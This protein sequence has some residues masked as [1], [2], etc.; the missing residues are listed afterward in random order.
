[1]RPGKEE[2]REILLLIALNLMIK[3]TSTK[4]VTRA[5]RGYNNMDHIDKIFSSSPSFKHIEI[6]QYFNYVPRFN[7]VFSRSSLSKIKD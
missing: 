1:M 4:R 3:A 6:T 5:G 2:E 7:G